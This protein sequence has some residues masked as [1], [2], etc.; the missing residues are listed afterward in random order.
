MHGV[1]LFANLKWWQLQRNS[2]RNNR[3]NVQRRK[4]IYFVLSIPWEGGGGGNTNGG[5]TKGILYSIWGDLDEAM[6]AGEVEGPNNAINRSCLVNFTTIILKDLIKER[7]YTF[8][9]SMIWRGR[10]HDWRW[11]H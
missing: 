1:N 2:T 5:G 11:D 4:K 9:M 3:M 10:K 7:K 6:F 8:D